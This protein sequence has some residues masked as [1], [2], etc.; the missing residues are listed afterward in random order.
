MDPGLF[1]IGHG[2]R[3]MLSVT[4]HQTGH[5]CNQSW[6]SFRLQPLMFGAASSPK[7]C[8]RKLTNSLALYKMKTI[9]YVSCSES[10]RK[11]VV[12]C[13]TLVHQLVV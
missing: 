10:V 3:T 13:I 1:M 9:C 11:R 6:L 12:L 4:C 5:S 8:F 7:P 2:A